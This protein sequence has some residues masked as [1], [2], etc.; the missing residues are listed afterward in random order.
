MTL[1]TRDLTVSKSL[2]FASTRT[3]S[4]FGPLRSDTSGAVLFSAQS[5]TRDRQTLEGNALAS[6]AFHS[7]SAHAPC[8]R[9]RAHDARCSHALSS[10][11]IW[12]SFC[13]PPRFACSRALLTLALSQTRTSNI[14]GSR[15][16]HLKEKMRVHGSRRSPKRLYVIR[17]IT[18]RSCPTAKEV[19][20]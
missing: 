6:T 5:C 17:V 20:E 10:S 11:A 19:D 14:S 3:Q 12:F 4:S 18:V 2:P 13:G 9:A 15:A 8:S 16:G 7:A 1:A